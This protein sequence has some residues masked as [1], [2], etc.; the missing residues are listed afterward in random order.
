MLLEDILKLVELWL[1]LI[2]KPQPY[3]D[4]NLDPVL[5]VSGIADSVLYAIDEES[6]AELNKS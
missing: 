1:K 3:M 6:G 5:L 2:K 4:P